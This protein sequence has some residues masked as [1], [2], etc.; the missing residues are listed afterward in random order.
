MDTTN[1]N[2]AA[3]ALSRSTLLHLT[4]GLDLRLLDVDDTHWEHRAEHDELATGRIMSVFDYTETWTWWERHPDGD[5]FVHVIAGEVD[6]VLDDGH[7]QRSA[8]LSSGEGTIV[9]RGSWH[10]AVLHRPS[11]MLFVTPTPARTEHRDAF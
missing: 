6:F 4:D 2:E 1:T 3:T 9:P 10:R 5:E 11:T 7:G 8:H